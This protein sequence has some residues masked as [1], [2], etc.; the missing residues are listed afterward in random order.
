MMWEGLQAAR[1][2]VLLFPVVFCPDVQ[3]A[4]SPVMRAGYK[5]LR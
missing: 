2:S 1:A 5:P 4:Q 3:A